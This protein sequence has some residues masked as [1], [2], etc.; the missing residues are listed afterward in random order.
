V[1][2]VRRFGFCNVDSKGD[3]Q[4]PTPTPGILYDYQ[5]KGDIEGV[6]WMIIKTKEISSTVYRSIAGC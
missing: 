5:K 1:D 3:G 6:V 2:R 4:A